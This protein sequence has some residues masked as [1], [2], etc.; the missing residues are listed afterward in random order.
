MIYYRNPYNDYEKGR[1]FWLW[2][3]I[4]MSVRIK[5]SRNNALEMLE[6]RSVYKMFLKGYYIDY[7]HKIT[8]D[9]W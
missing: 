3:Y 1:L 8:N 2:M 4:L 5:Y 9:A 6:I 7:K